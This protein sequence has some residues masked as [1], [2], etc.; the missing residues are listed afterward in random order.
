MLWS[1]QLQDGKTIATLMLAL[2]ELLQRFPALKNTLISGFSGSTDRA[3][4]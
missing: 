4:E 1:G 2:P 3:N